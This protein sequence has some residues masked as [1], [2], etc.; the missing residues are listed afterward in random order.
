[1]WKARGA[2]RNPRSPMN[3]ARAFEAAV[4]R[5]SPAQTIADQETLPI[6]SATIGPKP[7]RISNPAV[8]SRSRVSIA[9]PKRMASHAT[10]KSV[11]PNPALAW[12]VAELV[13]AVCCATFIITTSMFSLCPDHGSRRVTAHRL[14]A[15]SSNGKKAHRYLGHPPRERWGL[16]RSREEVRQ[17]LSYRELGNAG[18]GG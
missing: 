18:R 10:R 11:L 9:K 6:S 3:G 2:K 4:P 14:K 7:G 16:P 12:C 8:K 15:S 1:M 13:S 5:A 17:K